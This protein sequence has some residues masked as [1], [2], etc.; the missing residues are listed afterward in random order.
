MHCTKTLSNTVEEVKSIFSLNFGFLLRRA[1][2][3]LEWHFSIR[4]YLSVFRNIYRRAV[5]FWAATTRKTYW[6]A[7]R[8]GDFQMEPW[9]P[10]WAG[11]STKLWRFRQIATSDVHFTRFVEA[12][13]RH[14]YL[15][16]PRLG[17]VRLGRFT[18]TWTKRGTFQV[19]LQSFFLFRSTGV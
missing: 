13:Y 2:S 14:L 6:E 19:V 8:P 10:H 7:A 9:S 15:Y 12:W 11:N 17:V 1:K 18:A 16:R 5:N 4:L 3:T